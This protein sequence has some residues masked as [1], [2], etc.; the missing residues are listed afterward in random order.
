M[1]VNSLLSSKDFIGKWILIFNNYIGFCGKTGMSL[2]ILFQTCHCML[3]YSVDN[4]I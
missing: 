1:H 2:F 3:V 4:L